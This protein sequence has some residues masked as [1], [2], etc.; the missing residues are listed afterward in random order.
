MQLVRAGGVAQVGF[1]AFEGVLYTVGDTYDS[2]LNVL[3]SIAPMM[4]FLRLLLSREQ[5]NTYLP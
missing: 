1:P 4:A 3:A 2:H 5:L